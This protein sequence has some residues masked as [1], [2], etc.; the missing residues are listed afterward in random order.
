MKFSF[1][2]GI[3]KKQRSSRVNDDFVDYDENEMRIQI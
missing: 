1:L 3:E 2:E